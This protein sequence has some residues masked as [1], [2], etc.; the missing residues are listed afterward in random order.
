MYMKSL[1]TVITYVYDMHEHIRRVWG[2]IDCKGSLL[3]VI[4]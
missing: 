4:R 2:S 3:A 1:G